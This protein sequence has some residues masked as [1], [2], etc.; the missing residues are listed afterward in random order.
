[1]AVEPWPG[2]TARSRR[3]LRDAA[4]FLWDQQ[5]DDGGWH[6]RTYAL[7][8]SGQALTP[9]V[10]SV[11]MCVPEDVF[12]PPHKGVARA[13]DF[14]RRHS[15]GNGALGL[16]DPEILEYPNHSTAW[17]LRCLL[18]SS[19]EGDRGLVCRMVGFL[20]AAQYSEARGFPPTHLA[21]GGWGF[22]APRALGVAEHMD[23]SHTR[24]VLEAIRAADEFIEELV[25]PA[26]VY[27]RALRFLRLVQRHPAEDR[28]HPRPLD[29][30]DDAPEWDGRAPTFDGGFYFSPVVLTANKG[31][32]ER[33]PPHWRSYATATCDGLLAL[34]AAGVSPNDPR[35]KAAGEWLAHH[36]RLDYPEG[37]PTE[38]PGPW[39]AAIRFYHFAVRATCLATF[40]APGDWRDTLTDELAARQESDGRFV[41]RDSHLMKE[42][43]PLICTALAASALS[44]IAG[45]RRE[46]H[47]GSR[48]QGPFASI[49]FSG[50]VSERQGGVI[51]RFRPSRSASLRSGYGCRVG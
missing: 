35:V 18:A 13:L 15:A 37:V 51:R 12:E 7:L 31:G 26:Q 50:I 45:S 41:N 49:R 9:F 44:G 11:L 38:P 39:G 16:D 4:R 29:W 21:Y 30:P 27:E 48:S 10:L 23:I 40:D 5:A 8:R 43:D 24:H 46:P 42:D 25:V 36:P 6:S 19:R 20:I 32:W 3:T 34:L 47:Q 17:A 28:P 1:M 33:Q 14:L 22:A 2:A